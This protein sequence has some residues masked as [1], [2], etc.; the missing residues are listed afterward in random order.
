MYQTMKSEFTFG[1]LEFED[2]SEAIDLLTA[3]FA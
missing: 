1:E 2:I 3:S